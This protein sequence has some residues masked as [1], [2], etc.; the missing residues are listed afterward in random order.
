MFQ[1]KKLVEENS[2]PYLFFK[3]YER[4][5]PSERPRLEIAVMSSP[6]LSDRNDRILF[7][8]FLKEIENAECSVESATDFW[9]NAYEK[10]LEGLGFGE[11][12]QEIINDQQVV[13]F[14]FFTS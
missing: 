5:F 2:S 11:M 4:L 9:L 14:L 7:S 13:D 6:N 3:N 1:V 10:F 8:N 12:W